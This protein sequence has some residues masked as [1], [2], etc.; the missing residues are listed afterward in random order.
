LIP[1]NLPLAPERIAMPI[2]ITSTENTYSQSFDGL[3][4]TASTSNNAFNTDP[5]P[6]PGW[7][8]NETGGGAR[9]N[10]LYGVDTGSSN[11][12][13][14]YSYGTAGSTDRAL[15]SLL[16]GTLFSSFGAGFTN[17]TGATITQITVTYYGEQ[18]RISNTAAARDDRLDFQISTNATSITS[19]TWSDVNELDFTNIVKTA[20][21]AGALNGNAPENRVLITH[22]IT[23]LSIAPG[24][25]LWIRWLDF[26]SAGADD[27]L[28]IDDFTLT[29][30][31]A[32][33]PVPSLTIND[34]TKAEGDSGTTVFTFTVSLSEPAAAGGVTFDIAT[35]D[36]AA[37]A[38][39][40]YVANALTGQTIPAGE[41][42]YTFSVTVNGDTAIEPNED[43]FVNITNVTGATV[44]DGQGAGTI[45]N[46][47]VA[48]LP[49]ASVAGP[50]A[51]SRKGRAGF[52]T[53]FQRYARRSFSETVTIDYANRDATARGSDYLA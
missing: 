31:G 53:D 21:A 34:V 17:N 52:L 2:S 44:A 35:A 6:V 48:A 13:D 9:D 16:S 24:D 29:A 39:I 49:A 19:G 14:T 5:Q 27:G 37:A 50:P 36:G 15:G 23:G 11:T 33:A 51:I 32:T 20:A 12:G 1:L 41:T 4:S 8:I 45:E 3:S 25:T 30:K 18:Y 26:N 40:D 7:F 10:E 22:T 28:A 46:D 42:S 47:D 38:D 43:F